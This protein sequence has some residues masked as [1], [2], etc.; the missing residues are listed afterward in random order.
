MPSWY[1][2]GNHQPVF[3]PTVLTCCP[4]KVC[5]P[6]ALGK[7]VVIKSLVDPSCAPYIKGDSTRLKQIIVNL[8][9]NAVKFN[10]VQEDGSQGEVMLSVWSSPLSEQSPTEESTSAEKMDKFLQT[11][12][13][14]SDSVLLKGSQTT[15][16]EKTQQRSDK[17]DYWFEVKDN[18]IGMPDHFM[19]H[20]FGTFA[21]VN[22]STQRKYGKRIL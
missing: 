7:G 13:L 6:I 14:N 5:Q 10:R 16:K 8:V 17:R 22:R 12:N 15:R 20:I 19:K 3:F 4:R 18:G 21:Q 2:L 1:L 11:Y 9:S